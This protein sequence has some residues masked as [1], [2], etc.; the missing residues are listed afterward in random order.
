[1]ENGK[2][3][4]LTKKLEK[5]RPREQKFLATDQ[6]A[7]DENV[8][9]QKDNSKNRYATLMENDMDDDYEAKDTKHGKKE[10]TKRPMKQSNQSKQPTHRLIPLRSAVTLNKVAKKK[11]RRLLSTN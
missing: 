6:E 11:P 10:K 7:S 8:D 1:M 2:E 4:T 9:Q 5:I 3:Q